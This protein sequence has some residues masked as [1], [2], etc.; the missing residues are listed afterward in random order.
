MVL[1]WQQTI[2][3]EFKSVLIDEVHMPKL[4]KPTDEDQTKGFEA[5][6]WNEECTA[7]RD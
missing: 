1:P 3:P 4:N 6:N 7:S 5:P 2:G